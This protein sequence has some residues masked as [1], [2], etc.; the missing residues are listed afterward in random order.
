M[1]LYTLTM[2]ITAAAH[3]DDQLADE[4]AALNRLLL[5]HYEGSGESSFHISEVELGD[6]EWQRPDGQDD[7]DRVVLDMM[8][9]GVGVLDEDEDEDSDGEVA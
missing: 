1:N 7:L 5:D 6:D 4:V 3:G 9:D 8:R 2:T